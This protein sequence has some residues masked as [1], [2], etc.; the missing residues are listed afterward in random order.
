MHS[1]ALLIGFRKVIIQGI[2]Q[3][4]NDLYVCVHTHRLICY[5]QN[6]VSITTCRSLTRQ[7]AD[8]QESKWEVKRN[9]ILLS[10]WEQEEEKG[11]EEEEEKEE[12]KDEEK[13]RR[14]RSDFMVIV[15]DVKV[16]GVAA[17]CL[18]LS[19]PF[20]GPT[21]FPPLKLLCSPGPCV[22]RQQSLCNSDCSHRVKGCWGNFPAFPAL[23]EAPVS[24]PS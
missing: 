6:I 7:T 13:R 11:E 20:F 14:G 16:K 21:D 12:D 2:L 1:L 5:S 10:G 4:I 15:E 3:L 18:A 9:L 22:S 19:L 23:D 17:S 8:E 24:G